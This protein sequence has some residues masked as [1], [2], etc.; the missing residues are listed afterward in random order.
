MKSLL[1]IILLTIFPQFALSASGPYATSW[2]LLYGYGENQNNLNFKP[3][4]STYK[5]QGGYYFNKS[6]L[7]FLFRYSNLEDDLTFESTEGNLTHKMMTLGAHIGYW[8][9]PWI[10]FHIG[11]A[12][13]NIYEDS[14]GNF[15]NTQKNAITSL[16]NLDD[17]KTSGLYAG[18]DIVL[19]Q[20]KSFQLFSN[21]DIFRLNNLDSKE[22]EL[23]VGLRLYIESKKTGTGESF[24]TKI[25]EQIF[26]SSK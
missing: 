11:Y 9:F 17:R 10:K 5:A 3:T 8:I 19:L 15:T 14:K 1:L 16:Y 22:W 18:S 24:F 26:S 4:G 23:M 21:F 25:F 2:S 12:S 6:E 20:S 13:H 7:T